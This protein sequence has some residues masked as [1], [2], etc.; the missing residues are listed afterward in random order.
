MG[1]GCVIVD[2]AQE[3]PTLLDWLNRLV[4]ST[5]VAVALRGESA[6]ALRRGSGNPCGGG[7]IRCELHGLVPAGLGDGFD[8]VGTMRH[9]CLPPYD[10]VDDP[11]P[12]LSVWIDDYPNESAEI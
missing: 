7:A 8:L 5:G 1:S 6:R 2:E 4:E 3:A 11:R 9:G 12:L 10:R